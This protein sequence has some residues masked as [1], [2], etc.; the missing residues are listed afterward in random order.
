M[1][2]KIL[3]VYERW[4]DKQSKD[5]HSDK[6]AA[7]TVS[8]KDIVELCRLGIG[9][10]KKMMWPDTTRILLAF[11]AM[12]SKVKVRQLLFLPLRGALGE[13]LLTLAVAQMLKHTP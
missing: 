9:E 11:D 6:M 4:L 10:V 3:S 13:S 8:E 1:A 7:T 2:I 5:R 12:M